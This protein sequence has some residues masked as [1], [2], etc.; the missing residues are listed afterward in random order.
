MDVS[1]FLVITGPI[2]SGK[3]TIGFRVAEES[4][5]RFFPEDVDSALLDREVL[6]RYYR[7]VELFERL[8]DSG[9]DESRAARHEARRHVYETQVHFIRKRSEILKRI[10]AEGTRAVVERHPWDDI[11]IFSR[12][13]V[14]YGLLTRDQF[15][16]IYRLAEAEL[17]GIPPPRV[18]VFLSARPRNLRARIK[19]R[20]RVQ[21]KD[22]LSPENPYLEEIAELYEDWYAMYDGEKFRI[23]TDGIR[24]A[25]VV[26][27]IADEL[28]KRGVALV[29]VG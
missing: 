7:A 28:R 13:N 12:R 9:D 29:N 2:A 5:F 16:A 10:V 27:G 24:E 25:D 20:G 21:E 15:E 3:S 4:R 23:E 8:K 1:E 6:A 22:L 18:M 19:K 26:A 11:H 17:R 14:N